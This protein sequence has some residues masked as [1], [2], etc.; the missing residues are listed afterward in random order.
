M[1]KIMKM[2]FKNVWR[3]KRRTL[4]T[5]SMIAFGI[6][7]TM[8]VSGFLDSIS[9]DMVES[10]IEGETGD[11]QIMA[12]GYKEKKLSGSLDYRI[13]NLSQLMTELEQ[14]PE[15]E[16]ITKMITVTGLIGDG[17]QSINAWGTGVDISTVN[18]TLP[19]MLKEQA[20]GTR[21]LNLDLSDGVV[22]GE[23]LAQKLEVEIGDSLIYFA[24]DKYGSMT[25]TDLLVTDIT[26][27]AIDVLNDA[28]IMMT[29]S[30]AEYL[31]DFEDEATEVCIKVTDRT[32]VSGLVEYLQEKYGD[33]YDI[34]FYSWEDLLGGN[35]ET[36]GMFQTIQFIILVIMAIVVLIGV[37]NTILM[38]VFERTSEI[39]TLIALGTSKKRI[40][41][42]FVVESFWIG[43]VGGI[44]GAV[45]G[46][47]IIGLV[48]IKGIPFGAPGTT[49]TFYIK[50]ILNIGML[51]SAPIALTIVSILAAIYPA[52]FAAKLN[53][54]EAIRK[55]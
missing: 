39:G 5:V 43:V 35:A 40:I 15:I 4:F 16:S 53:P 10:V 29:F 7:V 11:I 44:M 17:R 13:K 54:I 38:S 3:N 22:L 49:E 23:G 48:G 51:I 41:Y 37:I 55:V 31:Y 52:R 19:L 20:T 26:K 2:S 14:E 12:K 34:A 46:A 45:L 8:F 32:K 50:P 1:F 28:K 21:S 9:Q 18:E 30:N 36:I 6:V 25:A 27:Y 33:K 42:M 47:I 24:Y